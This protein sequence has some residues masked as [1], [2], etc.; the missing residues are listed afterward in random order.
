MN[1]ILYLNLNTI[2][3]KFLDAL[4]LGRTTLEMIN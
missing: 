1:F 3:T 4:Y 2:H